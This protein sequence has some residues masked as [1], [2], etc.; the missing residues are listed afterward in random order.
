MLFACRLAGPALK[1]FRTLAK[2]EPV[3]E[4]VRSLQP[5]RE[6]EDNLLL[7]LAFGGA[8]AGIGSEILGALFAL[9]DQRPDQ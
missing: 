9:Q 5:H 1:F 2:L 3:K 6:P 7:F 8:D 4:E